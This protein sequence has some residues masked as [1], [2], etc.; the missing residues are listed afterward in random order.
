MPV[1]FSSCF[2][3]ADGTLKKIHPCDIALYILGNLKSKQIENPS[4][5]HGKVKVLILLPGLKVF[6][7]SIFLYYLILHQT[8]EFYHNAPLLL[9]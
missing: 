6:D 2:V 3:N 1:F 4:F 8:Y 9:L 5:P 7:P